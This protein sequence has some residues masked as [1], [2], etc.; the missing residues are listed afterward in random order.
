MKL[1]WKRDWTPKSRLALLK[2]Y[3]LSVYRVDNGWWWAC[4]SPKEVTQPHNACKTRL[5]AQHAAHRAL[6]R[7]M[8]KGEK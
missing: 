5:G 6:H 7:W 3:R 4:S 8:K 2:H 1:Q